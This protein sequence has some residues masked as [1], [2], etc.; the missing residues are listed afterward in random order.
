[1]INTT[2]S[3][4]GI[5]PIAQAPLEESERPDINSGPP[6]SF[7]I[8]FRNG[9]FVGY[10]RRLE[11]TA[12]D[13][14]YHRFTTSMSGCLNFTYEQEEAQGWCRQHQVDEE[15]SKRLSW[16]GQSPQA[17]GIEPCYWILQVD[18]EGHFEEVGGKPWRGRDE[19]VAMATYALDFLD[20]ERLTD[21]MDVDAV[22]AR[23][24]AVKYADYL[25]N[26]M[27]GEVALSLEQFSTGLATREADPT[28]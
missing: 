4:L 28:T 18:D 24:K 12:P 17:L 10:L 6:L 1:M 5:I 22:L 16:V 19:K 9:R 14:A 13:N 20:G 8:G 3:G 7:H 2:P 21:E 26:L 27:P 23:Y 11:T 25:E 15:T